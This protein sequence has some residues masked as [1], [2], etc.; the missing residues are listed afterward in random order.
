[1]KNSRNK[2]KIGLLVMAVLLAALFL[3]GVTNIDG[4]NQVGR[5]R[6]SVITR[7][8]FP[9]LFVIDTATGIVKWVGND[10]GKPFEEIKGR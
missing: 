8:N 7:G 2:L 5:Y 4:P 6:L 3:T 9:D 1:M 10:E